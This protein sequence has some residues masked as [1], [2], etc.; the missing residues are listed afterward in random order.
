[1]AANP[2]TYWS[3][4]CD[5]VDGDPCNEHFWDSD[6]E[7]VVL[8]NNLEQLH[9]WA[10]VEGWVRYGAKDLCPNTRIRVAGAPH[11]FTPGPD[12]LFCVVCRE[13]AE[14]Y[15]HHAAKRGQVTLLVRR[16]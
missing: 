2:A 9:E 13:W 1:M 12:G 10:A 8:A 7:C 15:R 14:D 5:G 4:S 16:P 3:L 6:N 11:T